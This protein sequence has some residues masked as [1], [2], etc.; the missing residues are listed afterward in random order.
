MEEF[1]FQTEGFKLHLMLTICKLEISEC[2]LIIYNFSYVL[3]S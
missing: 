3:Y 1:E 2:T